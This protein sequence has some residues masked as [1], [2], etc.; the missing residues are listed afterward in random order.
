MREGVGEGKTS[1]TDMLMQVWEDTERY[2]EVNGRGNIG[3][4]RRGDRENECGDIS[5]GGGG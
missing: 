4:E 5:E 3:V 1:M 2:S